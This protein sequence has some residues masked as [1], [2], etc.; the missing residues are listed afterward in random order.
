M[1]EKSKKSKSG[2]VM[3]YW[4]CVIEKDDKKSTSK[5]KDKKSDKSGTPKKSDKV[6]D[7]KSDKASKKKSDSGRFVVSNFTQ[8]V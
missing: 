2:V 8:I 6:S 4:L 1:S 3:N 7:R 5:E